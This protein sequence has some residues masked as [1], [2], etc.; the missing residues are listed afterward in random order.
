MIFDNLFETTDFY[1]GEKLYWNYWLHTWKTIS[2]SPFVNAVMLTSEESAVNSVEISPKALTVS[3]GQTATF[4]STVSGTGFY[5]KA[6]KYS[7]E[8]ETVH[9]YV[10]NDGVLHVGI[11]ETLSTLTVISTTVQG[12]KT[13]KATVTIS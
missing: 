1:N 8:E 5:N 12:G 6:V 4:T 11:N 3:H 9:S 2:N 7:L 13:S 10:T